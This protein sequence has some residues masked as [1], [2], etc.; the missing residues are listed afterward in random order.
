M[1]QSGI[2]VLCGYVCIMSGNGGDGASD[3][4][5]MT[6]Q[7][8]ARKH[9]VVKIIADCFNSDY[10][11]MGNSGSRYKPMRICSKL[12]S[13]NHTGIKEKV[14]TEVNL[15][16]K[17]CILGSPLKNINS[18]ARDRGVVACRRGSGG[19]RLLLTVKFGCR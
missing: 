18:R 7:K 13:R 4:A 5:H 3:S 11:M 2:G 16:R 19:G 14:A 6:G 10:L 1:S 9:W 12:R 15:R 17:N 8:L